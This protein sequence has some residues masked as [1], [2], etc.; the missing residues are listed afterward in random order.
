MD[1]KD[2]ETREPSWPRPSLPQET[3]VLDQKRTKQDIRPG[4]DLFFIAKHNFHDMKRT[5]KNEKKIMV[6]MGI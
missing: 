4:R 2:R 5:D 3:S 6:Q 1:G